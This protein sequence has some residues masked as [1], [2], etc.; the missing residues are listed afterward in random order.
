MLNRHIY[1]RRYFILVVVVLTRTCFS[2]LLYL[3][4]M[5][6]T[7]HARTPKMTHQSP[8]TLRGLQKN[9]LLFKSTT[10]IEAAS[11]EEHMQAASEFLRA[12]V[13]LPADADLLDYKVQYQ[14]MREI[15]Q[16]DREIQEATKARYQALLES[17]EQSRKKSAAWKKA[18]AE[19]KKV[20]EAQFQ[21]AQEYMASNFRFDRNG[22]II[23]YKTLK[24]V[25]RPV[26]ELITPKQDMEWDE[27]SDKGSEDLFAP[28]DTP[29]KPSH[30]ETIPDIPQ[31][32]QT[33]TPE[34]NP[35]SEVAS[36]VPDTFRG[37][38]TEHV[39]EWNSEIDAQYADVL[40][41]PHLSPAEFDEY[42]PTED[43]RA[44][45]Q[46]RQAQMLAVIAQRVEQVLTE[47]TGNRSEKLSIIR[48]TLTE[49]WGDEMANGVIER[50]K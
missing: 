13:S 4:K 18:Y 12:F 33:E 23:A 2:A 36:F 21:E 30:S 24:G 45:L 27:T 16:K 29:I 31:T 48:Q 32:P 28:T 10:E 7:Q 34:L 38:F 14:R 40:N 41:V 46:A 43:A 19:Q 15:E 39:L 20:S 50:L 11:H 37:A 26:S 35:V 25:F 44:E 47:D 6:Q 49:N 1:R 8:L 3:S 5:R 17:I 42:F 22:E 9:N